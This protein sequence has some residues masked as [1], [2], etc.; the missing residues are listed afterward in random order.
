MAGLTDFN[1]T[2]MR[3]QDFANLILG[4]LLF[5]SPWV[6][7]Y[8]DKEMAAR[9]AWISGVVIAVLALAAIVKFAEWEEWLNLLVG[10]AE[11][12]S[13]YIF[14]STNVMHAVTAHYVLGLLV[15]LSTGWE[16]WEVH[17]IPARA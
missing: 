6:L 7:D 16:L 8:T 3:F 5:V 12:A 17:H 11:S 1:K 13:P 4:G 2:A 9:I 14:G 15:V 10:L